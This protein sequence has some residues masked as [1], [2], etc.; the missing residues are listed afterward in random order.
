MFSTPKKLT[1]EVSNKGT[2]T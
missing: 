2:L 1:S